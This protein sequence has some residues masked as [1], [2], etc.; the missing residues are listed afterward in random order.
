MQNWYNSK[1]C[2]PHSQGQSPLLCTCGVGYLSDV[3]GYQQPFLRVVLM[4]KKTLSKWQMRTWENGDIFAPT[5]GSTQET[6]DGGAVSFGNHFDL[7]NHNFQKTLQ[8]KPVG[9]G[10]KSTSCSPC[11]ELEK[12]EFPSGLFISGGRKKQLRY[13]LRCKKAWTQANPAVQR[14]KM[15]CQSMTNLLQRQSHVR[16]GPQNLPQSCHL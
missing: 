9:L 6:R 1:L 16:V 3:S 15:G 5:C 12:H 13:H 14:S 10:P 11:F 4:L 2:F 8:S 7:Y